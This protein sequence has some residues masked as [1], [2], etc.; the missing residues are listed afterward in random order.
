ME[1]QKP[2]NLLVLLFKCCENMYGL[3][4]GIEIR[5]MMFKYWKLLF[6][7]QYLQQY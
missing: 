1:T 2:N 4:N 5:I 6:K 3:K 7:Q